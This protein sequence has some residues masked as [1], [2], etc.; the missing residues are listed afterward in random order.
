MVCVRSVAAVAAHRRYG[1]ASVCYSTS[2]AKDTLYGRLLEHGNPRV[3]IEPVLDRWVSQGRHV[4]E[5]G[6]TVLIKQLRTFKRYSHALEVSEWMSN[7]RYFELS[8]GGA[9]VRLDL[10]SKVRGLEEAE[11]YFNSLPTTFRDN[12]VYGALLNCYAHSNSLEKAEATM[13]TMKTLGF[14]NKT[15]SYNAMLNLYARMGQ[16]EKLDSLMEEMDERGIP[17]DKFTFN[18]RLHAYVIASDMEGMERLLMKMEA[19]TSGA[20]DWNAYVVA[21]N[22]YL[23]IGDLEKALAMLKK[24]EKLVKP[25]KKWFAYE[26]LLT[27]YASLGNKNEVRRLWNLYK[28]TGKVY[29][30]GYVSMIS[31]L[32]KVDDLDGA[33]Q[34]LAEWETEKTIFDLRVPT[35][36]INAYC[37]K[38]NIRKAESIV[39]RILESGKDVSAAT[40]ERLAALYLK[41]DQIDKALDSMKK[42]ISNMHLLQLSNFATLAECLECLKGRGSTE[43]A[44]ELIELLREKSLIGQDGCER[45]LDFVRSK[46]TMLKAHEILERYSGAG[47]GGR[48]VKDSGVEE[49]S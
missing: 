15:I 26:V 8:P 31:S 25:Y 47:G 41:D 17:C 48:D 35:T 16:H 30:M 13:E 29:N 12:R 1:I 27:V 32:V 11:K 24:S 10:I 22:G 42:V 40:W 4:D 46:E 45:L 21:A 9:A 38:G 23:K 37:K 33:E 36:L 3:S 7:K 49:L 2:A 34:V 39:S 19:N 5:K 18:T 43:K 28:Q 14:A 44:E 6:L 20:R